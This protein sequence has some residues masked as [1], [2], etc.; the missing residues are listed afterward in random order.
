MEVT[1]PSQY[2]YVGREVCNRCPVWDVCLEKGMDEVWGMWGGLTPNERKAINDPS[3]PHL[4]PHGTIPR[5]RQ[6]CNCDLCQD[7]AYVELKPIDTLFIPYSD[8]VF[9]I[10]EVKD[11]I[12]RLVE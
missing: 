1:N 7:A 6:G 12:Q 11:S 5:F 2:Y 8:E 10:S 4:Q 3:N 9:V